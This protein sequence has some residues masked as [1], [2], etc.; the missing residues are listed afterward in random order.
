MD[1]CGSNPSCSRVN[2]T[3]D[4]PSS[5][6]HPARKWRCKPSSPSPT[7]PPA[8]TAV[9]SISPASGQ[10][11]LPSIHAPTKF[12]AGNSPW[13]WLKVKYSLKNDI[14]SQDPTPDQDP[15][16]GK[17]ILDSLSPAATC[18]PSPPSVPS[19]MTMCQLTILPLSLLQALR[20]LQD[21]DHQ[22]PKHSMQDSQDLGPVQYVP[23]GPCVALG[24]QSPVPQTYRT[25]PALLEKPAFLVSP[26][27]TCQNPMQL[28]GAPLK[29]QPPIFPAG[30]PMQL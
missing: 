17:R 16:M 19:V 21:I 25:S 24:L 5:P 27:S 2:S 6:T 1:P 3:C 12:K 30:E 9:P 20:C 23:L 26:P 13:S 4:C 14:S 18:A 11:G 8:P 10:N 15:L 29:G 28:K 22:V 7:H